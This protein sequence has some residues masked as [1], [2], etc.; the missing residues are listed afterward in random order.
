L[1][2]A[3]LECARLHAYNTS[4]LLEKQK[5]V[6][7]RQDAEAKCDAM[8]AR[9]EKEQLEASEQREEESK[10]WKNYIAAEVEK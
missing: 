10:H 4:V 9:C 7:S 8:I 5:E 3:K 1:K 2:N 6:Q